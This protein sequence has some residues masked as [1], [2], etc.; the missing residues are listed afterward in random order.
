MVRAEQTATCSRMG[1][2]TGRWLL[3][4]LTQCS[5]FVWQASESCTSDVSATAVGSPHSMNGD[6]RC[7][8]SD[9]N[10]KLAVGAVV[11]QMHLSICIVG[12]S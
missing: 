2:S 4:R 7:V 1:W 11:S 8:L 9:W 12:A 5:A 3:Q 10:G 6:L